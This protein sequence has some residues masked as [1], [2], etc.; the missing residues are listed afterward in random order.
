MEQETIQTIE[1]LFQAKALLYAD[2]VECFRKERAR[3]GAMDVESLWA[4]ADEKNR[5]CSEIGA[6]KSRIAST[7]DLDRD[8]EGHDVTHFLDRIPVWQ[9][10]AVRNA[11][12]RIMK[13]KSEI[14]TMRKENQVFID[15]SLEFLDEMI[16]L[17]AGE[18]AGG[19]IYSGRRR[20]QRTEAV[21]TMSR[22]V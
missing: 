14:E 12:L 22:E 11:L 13:L 8:L 19:M 3:L 6:L 16:S 4:V 2:L 5:L 15:E 9:Q 1:R 20:L 18:R 17:L 10:G 7:L 21:V